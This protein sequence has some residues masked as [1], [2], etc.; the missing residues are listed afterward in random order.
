MFWSILWHVTG[1]FRWIKCVLREKIVLKIEVMTALPLNKSH[2]MVVCCGTF[3][4]SDGRFQMNKIVTGD[5]LYRTFHIFCLNVKTYVE[6]EHTVCKG[7]MLDLERYAL[8]C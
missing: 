3:C 1:V 2:G 7:P 8:G 5:L 6:N 4:C